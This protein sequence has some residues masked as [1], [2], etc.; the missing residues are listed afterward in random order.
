MLENTFFVMYFILVIALF[1]VAF[2]API[3]R[4][5]VYY[6]LIFQA[7]T[8]IKKTPYYLQRTDASGV[9]PAGKLINTTQPLSNQSET[10]YQIGRSFS[11]YFYTSTLSA[12][13]IENGSWTLYIWASTGSSGKVSRLTA[14]IY[15]VSSDGTIEKATIGSITDVIIDYGYSER[16]ITISGSTASMTDGDR[17]RLT[18]HAQSGAQNDPAGMSFY[19]DGYGAYETSAHET[20][21]QP[22]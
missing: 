2:M 21:L 18:L 11:V 15:L 16:I 13:S 10:T 19:Y 22:P 7:S 9:T 8:I 14:L 1:S 4:S 17:I 20:R 6:S 5:P 12:G 3:V